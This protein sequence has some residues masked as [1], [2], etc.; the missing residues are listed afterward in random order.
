MTRQQLLAQAIRDSQTFLARYMKGFD[1][2]NR[3]KQAPNVPNHFAWTMGHLALT[4]HRCAE[5]LDRQPVP[6]SDFI[7]ADG[8]G[9]NA[10]RFDTE[11][12]AFNSQPV[13]DASLYPRADR[14]T[15][16]FAAA[17][18]RFAAAV[19]RA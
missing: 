3:A 9:G 2:S 4:M 12:V 5:K 17:V 11:S 7:K 13:D 10:E 19:E 8:R 6:P 1:D 14:C 18:E 16:I 15:A